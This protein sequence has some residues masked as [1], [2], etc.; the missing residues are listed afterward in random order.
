MLKTKEEYLQSLRDQ[1]PKVY[2]QGKQ[3]D[4]VVDHPVFQPGIACCCVTYEAQHDPEYRDQVLVD[5]PLIGDKVNRWV[6][7]PQSADDLITRAR[8]IREFSRN[9]VC[10]FRCLTVDPLCSLWV[11][12][13]DID[14]K[15]G[16]DYHQRFVEYAKYIQANDLFASG[17]IMDARGDRSLRPHQQAD[18]DLYLHVVER[19]KK[20]IVVRGAK[21]NISSVPYTNEFIALPSRALTEKDKEYAVA[22]AVPV[23]T[24]GITYISRPAGTPKTSK[25][26]E[27]PISSRSG[28]AIEMIIFE[29]VF[30]P[31][32][33]VFLC[34]E[35]DFAGLAALH[36]ASIH[37]WSK[38]GC[39]AAQIDQKIGAA[40][41]LAEY[42][43][44]G[45]RW[46][47]R[48]TL[49]QMMVDAEIGYATA[50]AS[51]IEGHLHPSGCF[52]PNY[53]L[54][55]VGKLHCGV[56]VGRHY[57]AVQEIG[58]GLTVTSP[59]EEDYFNPETHDLI[60][61]YLKGKESVPTE[62]RYRAY[63]LAEDLVASRWAGGYISTAINAAGSP[64]AEKIQ[65][66]REYDL[67]VVK[68]IARHLAGIGESK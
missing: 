35:W 46:N 45:H 7:I 5:S 41:L 18:P 16:T 39:L 24:E 21:A 57:M 59:F 37:R 42:N 12:T 27:H 60:E 56:S 32:E 3:V 6:H 8:L 54:A 52:L 66:E 28:H 36:F 31:W 65:I 51:A 43:G 40:A 49:V 67:E 4:S 64:M 48:D 25:K 53:L 14:Q 58:G 63:K 19:N 61:K 55:N 20:G 38:C 22:F 23:D 17:G 62:H 2:T 30:V 15:Y 26:I 10:L 44:V 9:R 11:T 1:H 50:L 33:R 34:G 47:I 13:Y 29:D 68:D